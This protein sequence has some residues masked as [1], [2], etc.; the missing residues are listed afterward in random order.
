[1]SGASRI[2]LD[3]NVV[4]QIISQDIRKA[5]MVHGFLRAEPCISVQ[6]LNEF[7]SVAR[8]KYKMPWDALRELTAPMK[9]FCTV[10][11][12]TL[13]SH[14]LAARIAEASMLN[15]YDA[16]ILASAELAGCH[17]LFTEDLNN[18]QRIGGI[19]IRN[20]FD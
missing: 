1:M 8:R 9:F 20:P 5:D 19:T 6:V 14:G 11:P 2:F 16:N 10:V 15:I 17:T 13:E 18:G 12:L 3:S 7:V 4:L